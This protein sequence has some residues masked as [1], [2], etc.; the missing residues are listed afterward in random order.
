MREAAVKPV[1]GPNNLLQRKP[2][3]ACHLQPPHQTAKG[4]TLLGLGVLMQLSK[5]TVQFILLS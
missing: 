5:K 2:L 1:K 4:S 3:H